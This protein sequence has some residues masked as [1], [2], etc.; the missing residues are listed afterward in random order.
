MRLYLCCRR[1]CSAG[2][3]KGQQRKAHAIA[4]GRDVFDKYVPGPL[5][6]V[7]ACICKLAD[8]QLFSNA[9]GSQLAQAA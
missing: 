3:P 5:S 7:A 4:T 8:K 2:S 9:F 1:R 6:R